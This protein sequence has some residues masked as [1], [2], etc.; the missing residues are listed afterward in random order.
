VIIALR[1]TISWASFGD[2]LL[3]GFDNSLS[4]TLNEI[5]LSLEAFFGIAAMLFLIM[6][7]LVD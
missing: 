3:H 1:D 6:A 2:R 7:V 4:L 5:E